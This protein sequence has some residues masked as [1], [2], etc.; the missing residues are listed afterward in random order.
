MATG[1]Q[2]ETVGTGYAILSRD[3]VAGED[4][5]VKV[6]HVVWREEQAVDMVTRL[7][8]LATTGPG[9]YWWQAVWVARPDA[10]A[11]VS[12][13]PADRDKLEFA[14]LHGV[15]N[16][17]RPIGVF[18]SFIFNLPGALA[19]CDELRALGWPDV[20][21]DEELEGDECW[22]AYAH[23]RRLVLSEESI[24]H[25]RAEMEDVAERHRGTFDGWDVSGGA[26]LA[27]AKPGEIPT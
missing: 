8:A 17:D 2:T 19:A 22:H 14:R 9:G 7:N 26:G 3:H 11:P 20:G 25:L 10:G 21:T 12:L 16:T 1:C 15:L 13:T 4:P 23:K 6:V 24:A 27:R 5:T 18:F